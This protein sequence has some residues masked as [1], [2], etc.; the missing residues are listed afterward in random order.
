MSRGLA[1]V[2]RASVFASVLASAASGCESVP[3]LTFADVDGPGDAADTDATDDAPE[4]SPADVEAGAE[5]A[6][7][8]SPPPGTSV[9][10]GAVACEGLC[11][12]QCDTCAA[13]C[14]TPGEFCC[15]KNNNVLCLSAG[16]IC[17]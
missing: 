13:R 12:G 9:C 5:A 2:L 1:F 16:S 8:E 14:T 17:H 15:A 7:P 11:A 3:V 4:T 6:C 10:C